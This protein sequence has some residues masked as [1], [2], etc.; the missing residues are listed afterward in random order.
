MKMPDLRAIED[1]FL[2]YFNITEAKARLSELVRKATIGEEVIIAKNNR[3]VA[4]L[5]PVALQVVRR[6][7][8][9]CKGQVWIAPDFDG[10]PAD[11]EAYTEC[12]GR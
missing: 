6:K 3:P 5:V 10:M 7:P 8:G 2:A 1:I 11:F 9:S 12:A 4:K